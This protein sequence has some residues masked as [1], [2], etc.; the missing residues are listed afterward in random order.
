MQTIESKRVDPLA[1]FAGAHE[2]EKAL[3]EDLRREVWDRI[4]KTKEV[5]DLPTLEICVKDVA[6]RHT[7]SL[8][9]IMALLT[10]YLQVLM[11]VERRYQLRDVS[12]IPKEIKELLGVDQRIGRYPF[13]VDP[14]ENV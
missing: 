4:I 11:V 13:P 14:A 1:P 5:C 9:E 12:R 3:R 2:R 7:H 6:S 10:P 8:E